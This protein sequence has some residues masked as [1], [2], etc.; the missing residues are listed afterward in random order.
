M[1]ARWAF[2]HASRLVAA[3][4]SA[5]ARAALRTCGRARARHD[6]HALLVAHTTS[7]GMHV[8]AAD[9]HRPAERAQPV[10]GARDRE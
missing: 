7:P 1:R 8:D 2:S 4:F 10:L 5:R 6:D 9:A 3:S